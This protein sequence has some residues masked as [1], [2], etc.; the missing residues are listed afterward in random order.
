M[1]I[2]K[3]YLRDFEQFQ[4]VDLDFTHPDTGEPLDKICFIGSN[5]TG[6][7][8]I[9][10][11]INWFL[12]GLNN[13]LGS[14][15]EEINFENR[16]QKGNVIFETLYDNK[17]YFFYFDNFTTSIF[18]KNNILDN[19]NLYNSGGEIANNI[20]LFVTKAVNDNN[21]AKTVSLLQGDSFSDKFKLENNSKDLVIYSPTESSS[22]G[23]KDIIDVPF[24]SVSEALEFSNNFPFYSSVSSEHV[25]IFWKLLVYNLRKRAEEKDDFEN[26]PNNLIKIKQDLIN[27]FDGFYPKVLDKL[28]EVWNKILDKAGLYFDVKGASNPYQLND[29]LKAYIKL[30][31]NNEIVPYGELSTG[32]RN[33]IFRLGHIFSL[34]FNRE[35]DRGFLLVDEPE[36]SLFPD[37]LFDLMDTY[38]NVIVDKRGQNNTQVF[39]ATHN[40]IV[41]A[42][43]Q[44]YERV[45]LEWKEDGSVKAKKGFSPIGDDPNDILSNDFE[46]KDLMGPVGMQKW[47]EYISLKKKLAKS[48]ED[49]AKSQLIHEIEKIGSLY[50][51]N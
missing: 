3:I 41:A 30:K 47:E 15:I 26:Q 37:F 12:K 46:L 13:E 23:Y 45:I 1:K 49:S 48:T 22:N 44:P 31:S 42:Q 19:S 21:L 8:K 36:N 29:N 5:G 43:F 6:K 38:K 25:N 50:N 27:E 35:I 10:R 18:L 17:I 7:S 51:F 24:T 16:I 9:L 39:F 20:F 28:G 4:N 2:C 32:I 34:Y 40:P 33:Y 14:T 11:L